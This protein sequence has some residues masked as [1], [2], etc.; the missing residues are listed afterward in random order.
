MMCGGCCIDALI[1]ELSCCLLHLF[2][3]IDHLFVLNK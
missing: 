1:C 3:F 2:E